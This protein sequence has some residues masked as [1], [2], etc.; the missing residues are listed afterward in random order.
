MDKYC[1]SMINL[2]MMLNDMYI[3]NNQDQNSK[4]KCLRYLK[5]DSRFIQRRRRKR[6]KLANTL[7][8]EK[9]CRVLVLA[10]SV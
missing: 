7:V 9:E 5:D 8:R 10:V 6:N 1:I 3:Q 4:E 2:V